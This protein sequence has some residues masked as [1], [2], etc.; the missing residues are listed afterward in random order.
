MDDIAIK[1]E[2]KFKNHVQKVSVY[3]DLKFPVWGKLFVFYRMVCCSQQS[4]VN[5]C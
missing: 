2:K 3:S 1:S 5:I 4:Y